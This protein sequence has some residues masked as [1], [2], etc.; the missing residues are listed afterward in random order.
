MR[1]RRG[2]N[3]KGKTLWPLSAVILT[4]CL[5]AGCKTSAQVQTP[6][7]EPTAVPTVEA[8][9]GETAAPFSFADLSGLE[10]WFGSGAGAWCTIFSVNQDGTFEGEY[11]DS[12]M[13]VMDLCNF[14]GKFTGP[15]KVNDF[16]Y[17]VT[18]EQIV[19]EKEPG[20]EESKGELYIYYVDAYGFNDAEELLLYLPGAPVEELPEEYLKWVGR[21]GDS[22]KTVLPFY[23]FYNVNGEQG[24]S[25]HRKTT[26][27]DE[28]AFL[29]QEETFQEG[30]IGAEVTSQAG[31]TE[32]ASEIYRMWDDKL[33]EIWARLK[34]T[35]D[36]PDMETLAAQELEWIANK[37]AAMKEAGVDVAVGTLQHMLE[38]E[39]GAKLTKARVYELASYFL[40]EEAQ[41][42]AMESYRDILLGSAEFL[43]AP[44]GTYFER[45]DITAARTMFNPDSNDAKI[46]SFVAID[47]DGDG[48]N[49]AVLQITDVGNDVGGYLILHRENG[50]IYCFQSNNRTFWDLKID[51]T[52]QYSNPAGQEDG[53]ASI[54]FAEKNYTVEK[55][56]CATG[57]HYE[58][59]RFTVGGQQVSHEEYQAAWENQRQKPDV[60]WY[61]FTEANIKAVF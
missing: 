27:Y 25:S 28:L 49:E 34:E 59:D 16:T 36:E 6:A 21:Y 35:L 3:M 50:K 31:M 52:F 30:R 23:G 54:R 9:G 53:V 44:D 61:A 37:A 41:T 1:P 42:T 10:F 56:I 26:L 55:I 8:P 46:W 32:I 39:T 38:Y 48:E 2:R 58:F 15:V 4:L 33:N 22:R 47:L 5:L 13:N 18:L 17:S 14:T 40:P 57:D 24:Y 43:Y 7:P 11:R 12:D 51:G 20:T 60:A 19:F 29:E 45:M